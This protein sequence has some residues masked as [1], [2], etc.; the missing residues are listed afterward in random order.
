MERASENEVA[1]LYFLCMNECM[2]ALESE[3]QHRTEGERERKREEGEGGE[4]LTA[5]RVHSLL[6]G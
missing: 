5:L 4:R 6:Y 1:S 2:R 3:E